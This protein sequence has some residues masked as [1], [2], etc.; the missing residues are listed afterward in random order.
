MTA[1]SSAVQ[2]QG[3]YLVGSCQTL[4][5]HMER[6]N[7]NFSEYAYNITLRIV[8]APENYMEKCVELIPQ[9]I[10]G[11]YVEYLEAELLPVDF[12]PYPGHFAL[13]H[14]KEAIEKIKQE[15]R[16]AYIRLYQ[17]AMERLNARHT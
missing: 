5:K 7:V 11:K 15:M 6:G 9:N 13:D 10:L 1:L 14:S 2:A 4:T 8:D 17:L 16:P 3:E 12:M